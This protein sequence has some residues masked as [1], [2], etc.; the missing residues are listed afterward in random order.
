MIARLRRLL[1]GAPRPGEWARPFRRALV[2]EPP[3]AFEGAS[4]PRPAAAR[5]V[6]GRRHGGAWSLHVPAST[7]PADVWGGTCAPTDD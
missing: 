5:A 3:A 2:L 6:R 1:L 7:R 4:R